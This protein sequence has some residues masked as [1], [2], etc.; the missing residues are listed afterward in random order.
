M[1]HFSIRS[2]DIINEGELSPRQKVAVNASVD[3]ELPELQE[4][5]PP[6]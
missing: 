3:L 5:I 1:E 4:N 2:S 6:Q